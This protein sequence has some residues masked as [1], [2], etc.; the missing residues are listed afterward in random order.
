[1]KLTVRKLII[2][3]SAVIAIGFA[4]AVAASTYSLSVLRVGGPVY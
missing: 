2:V 4:A 1:M 3:G